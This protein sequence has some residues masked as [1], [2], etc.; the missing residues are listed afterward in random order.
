MHP[1]VRTSALFLLLATGCTGEPD[2]MRDRVICAVLLSVL[3]ACLYYLAISYGFD[4]YL[5]RLI[6]DIRRRCAYG[7][8][9][10]HRGYSCRTCAARAGTITLLQTDVATLQ[11][12][13]ATDEAHLNASAAKCNALGKHIAELE[14]ERELLRDQLEACQDALAAE[15]AR[16]DEHD[17]KER[18]KRQRA[19]RRERRRR[20][21]AVAAEHQRIQEEEDETA[22]LV[23]QEQADEAESRF[24]A[25]ADAIAHDVA[26]KHVLHDAAHTHHA[27][28]ALI[29]WGDLD[30]GVEHGAAL[31]HT[32]ECIKLRLAW[33][34]VTLRESFKALQ[35]WK[36]FDAQMQAKLTHDDAAA[37]RQHEQT[38]AEL[39]TRQAEAR[40]LTQEARRDTYARD[41]G[42]DED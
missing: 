6:L 12:V 31:K 35:H 16:R 14:C 27:T 25:Q 30:R 29:Y 11:S 19:R 38:I 41:L 23:A 21:A 5:D 28:A 4:T 20:D 34:P 40:R 37:A 2:A 26:Q 7:L 9:C 13:H 15:C 1:F 17:K 39:Q 36:L 22:A 3:L 32:Y 33:N 18:L 10:P 8:P 42:H 24:V